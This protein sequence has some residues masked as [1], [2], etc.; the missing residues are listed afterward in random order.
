MCKQKIE[1]DCISQCAGLRTSVHTS[2]RYAASGAATVAG[3][4]RARRSLDAGCRRA[5]H[6]PPPHPRAFPP[7]RL[8]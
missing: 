8:R 6:L 5:R 3:G 2:M 1:E 4:L 7:P